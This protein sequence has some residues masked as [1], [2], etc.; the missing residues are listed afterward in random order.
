[1]SA[2]HPLH[3]VLPTKSLDEGTDAVW[4]GGVPEVWP[5]S[6]ISMVRNSGRNLDIG[7]P[8]AILVPRLGTGGR[9]VDTHKS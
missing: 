8:E 4:P 1:M 5:Q 9:A 7:I 6:G 3:T 2:W